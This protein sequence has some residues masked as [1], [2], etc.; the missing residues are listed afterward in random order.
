VSPTTGSGLAPA[1]P[2][3]VRTDAQPPAWDGSAMNTNRRKRPALD[4][5]FDALVQP[6]R[7]R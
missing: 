1:I 4:L 3:A 7:F 2:R 6:V 5:F